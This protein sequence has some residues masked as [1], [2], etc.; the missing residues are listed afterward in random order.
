MHV[1]T[2]RPAKPIQFKVPYH[3]HPPPSQQQWTNAG[4]AKPKYSEMVIRF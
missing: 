1:S 3:P 4:D 2:L